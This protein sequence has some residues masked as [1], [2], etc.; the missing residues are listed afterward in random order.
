MKRQ[1]ISAAL[2]RIAVYLA[3]IIT[4]GSLLFVVGYILVKGVPHLS[5]KLFEWRYSTENLSLLPALPTL[6]WAAKVEPA[7]VIR[8]M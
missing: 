6:R 4:V 7:Q 3:A 8:D 2:L 1:K 5:W